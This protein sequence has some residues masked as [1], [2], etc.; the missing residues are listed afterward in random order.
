MKKVTET[1]SSHHPHIHTHIHT[2]IHTHAY[3]HTYTH[4]YT[5]IHTHTIHKNKTVKKIVMSRT[6]L[7]SKIK[8]TTV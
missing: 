6:S 8:K 5:H 1:F 2:P 3:T 7:K 4:P